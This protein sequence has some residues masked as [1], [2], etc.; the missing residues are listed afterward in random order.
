MRYFIRSAEFKDI[1][2]ILALTQ[3]FPLCSLPSNKSKLEE[4]IQTSQESFNKTLKPFLRNYIF[5]LEDSK[6]KKV[7]GSS[8]ILSYFGP[9]RSLCYFLEKKR[10]GSYLKIKQ[11]IKGRHQIGGLILNPRYRKSKEVLGLQIGMARF[12][13]IKTF[14]TDF[15]KTIEVSLT[16]PIQK[17]NN[18]FWQETG[19]K[20]LNKSYLSALKAFQKN[21]KEFLRAFPKNLKIEIKKL[22]PQA[23]LCLSAV[24]SQ[25]LPA[26]KGL[27]K[28]G[29][30]KSRYYHLL[31]GGIY[32]TADW[33]KLP[34]LKS[35]QNLKIQ[36]QNS[37]NQEDHFIAQ[38][39]KKGFICVKAK[40][41]KKGRN[42]I[43]KKNSLLKEGKQ[44][45]SLKF[46]F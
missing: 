18:P 32:L 9:N 3:Y 7:I 35:A 12:L 20:F 29:F 17:T 42:L 4:K 14:P 40:A 33:S 38:Q 28:R 5:V 31:D 6:K 27:L 16:A 15:S 30:H 39:T 21:R 46:P 2:E 36:Y 24:H 10:A 22:S 26:Y 11:I 25:T 43:L 34:F 23:Q 13:Y 8:Q 1:P 37:I 41:Q 44:A 19:A 45:L